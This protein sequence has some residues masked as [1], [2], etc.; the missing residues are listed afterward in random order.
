MEP[1][2]RDLERSQPTRPSFAV[3]CTAIVPVTGSTFVIDQDGAGY[4]D[5]HKRK[6]GLKIENG[7]DFGSLNVYRMVW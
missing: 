7:H 3:N 5:K 6:P 2:R 1:G 4:G